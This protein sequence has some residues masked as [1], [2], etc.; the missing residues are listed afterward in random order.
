MCVFSALKQHLRS[1]QKARR[2]EVRARVV[3]KA[4]EE[5]DAGH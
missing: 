1:I 2:I 3:Y 4:M 5:V